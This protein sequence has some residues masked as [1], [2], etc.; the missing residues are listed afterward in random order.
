MSTNDITVKQNV[1]GDYEIHFNCKDMQDFEI[2]DG[3]KSA[4][5]P[6]RLI[7]AAALICLTGS[8][9]SEMSK[10]KP[11]AKYGE[12]RAHATYKLGKDDAGRYSADQMDL[13]LEADVDE[14]DLVEHQALVKMFEEHGCVWTRSL[15]KGFKINYHLR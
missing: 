10:M 12:I 1:N 7:A 2:R 8:L 4:F 3:D 6:G 9:S 14:K 13:F 5:S 11:D 15:K